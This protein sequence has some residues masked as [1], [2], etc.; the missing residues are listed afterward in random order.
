MD[1]NPIL[2]EARELIGL[3]KGVI[4]RCETVITEAETP[5]LR[6]GDEIQCIEGCDKGKLYY[7]LYIKDAVKQDGVNPLVAVDEN[8]WSCGN[9]QNA[10]EKKCVKTDRNIFDDLKAM[11][12]DVEE[13]EVD[14]GTYMSLK[15]SWN[16]NKITIGDGHGFV[17][18]D[19]HE[20]PAFILNLRR[21]QAT[22]EREKNDANNS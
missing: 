14:N 18:I 12:E 8:G 1:N 7:C 9:I 17:L 13:F 4:S 6:H 19:H 16:G 10:R 2:E 5:E 22:H 15:V 21:L 20:I 11:A 3:A